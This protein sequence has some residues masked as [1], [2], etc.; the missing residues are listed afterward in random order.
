MLAAACST[1]DDGT[2]IRPDPT[3][4]PSA[5]PTASPEVGRSS[6]APPAVTESDVPVRLTVDG[7]DLDL[8]V[9]PV[10]VAE[11][12]QMDLP[13]NLDTVGWYRYGPAPGD[14]EGSA[15]FGGHV[16]SFEEGLGP[17][18]RLVDTPI[19]GSIVVDTSEGERVEYEVVSVES[20]SRAG[21]DLRSLFRRTGEEQ[22]VVVT[23]GGAYDRERGAYEENVIVTAVPR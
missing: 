18:A 21:V 22:I 4:S 3:D 9:V 17:L 23:C 16:D 1:S 13:S 19:G 6:A 12:G 5:T 14:A 20:I 8:A 15:V 10:G 2:R 7:A 11:D